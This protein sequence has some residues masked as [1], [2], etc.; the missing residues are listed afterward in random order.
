V[1]RRLRDELGA[2]FAL[3]DLFKHATVAALA[4][5][6]GGASDDGA[7]TRIKDEAE[8]RRSAIGRRQAVAQA[9]LRP[10]GDS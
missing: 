6:L 8:R 4:Q 1:H 7:A 5:R 3:I 9:R 10:R 2:G